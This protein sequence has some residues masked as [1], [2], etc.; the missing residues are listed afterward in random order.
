MKGLRRV[1]PVIASQGISRRQVLSGA[2]GAFALAGGFGGPL[3]YA[4]R[5]LA[6]SP[7]PTKGG[8]LVAAGEAIGDNFGPAV[9]FQG[10]WL[11]R[12][13][14]GTLGALTVA[15]DLYERQGSSVSAED[16][17]TI[18]SNRANRLVSR[19]EVEAVLDRSGWIA[20][21]VSVTAR[22]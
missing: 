10:N 20:C 14:E 5:A 3:G 1:T 4:T 7:P 11:R 8:T 9:S 12:T 19:A 6:Q 16:V 15:A 13:H 21:E 17:A 18:L 22:L 2:G